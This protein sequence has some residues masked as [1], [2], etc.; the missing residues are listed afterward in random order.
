M[1]YGEYVLYEHYCHL[2]LSTEQS[3]QIDFEHI[4]NVDGLRQTGRKD[5]ST[6]R[7]YWS[8]KAGMTKLY[9]CL[10][11]RPEK[12][13]VQC[14]SHLTLDKISSPPKEVAAY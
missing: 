8:I 13:N 3:E 12:H 6:L 7:T 1:K 11:S 14:K 2:R 9:T 5:E 10:Y 4:V